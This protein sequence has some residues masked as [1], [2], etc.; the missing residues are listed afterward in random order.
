MSNM[1]YCRFHN[2][3]LDFQDC[4][5]DIESRFLNDGLNEHGESLSYQEAAAMKS[6]YQMAADLVTAYDECEIAEIADAEETEKT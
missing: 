6:L 2:T 4:I 1:S 5:D 3:A